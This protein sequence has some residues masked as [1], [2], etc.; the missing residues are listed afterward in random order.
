[1]PLTFA[2]SQPIRPSRSGAGLP[3]SV[4]V[5]RAY[6]GKAIEYGLDTAF[7]DAGKQF[8]ILP[9]DPGLLELADAYAKMDGSAAKKQ[10]VESLT[11]KPGPVRK[12]K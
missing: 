3:R 5:C 10:K 1:M 7:V 12:P 9:A 8:G 4:G 11:E 2:Q 6:I